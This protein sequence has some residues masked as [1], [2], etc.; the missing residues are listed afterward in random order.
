MTNPQTSAGLS[1]LTVL[2]PA[3]NEADRVGATIDSLRRQDRQPDRI[4]V[5]SDNSTDATVRVVRGLNVE[6]FETVGNVH[7]KAG[8]LNQAIAHFDPV[9]FVL[10][11]D[12]DTVLADGWISTAESLLA[13]DAALGAVGAVFHAERN[14]TL[15]TQF[16]ANEYTRYARELDRTGRVMVL[17]G[18]AA[19]LRSAVL[20]DVAR[21][22]S[23]SLPGTHGDVYDVHAQTEDNELTLAIKTLGWSLA[24]PA[25]CATVTEVMP[26]WGDLYRQRLRWYRGALENL[27]AYGVT[28]VTRRYW[29]QQIMLSVGVAALWLYLGLTAVSLIV[30]HA[31][32]LSPFWTGVTVVFLIERVVTAWAGGL[33]GRI[34]AGTL[35]LELFYEM[36]LQFVFIRAVLDIVTRREAKWHHVATA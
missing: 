28:P 12:A 14:D 13:A 2:I 6:V 22:R 11:M 9:G 30:G 10:V 8:A 23:T 34:L 21:S 32:T 35:Y 19:L 3:H 31:F 25:A 18:T 5:V 7:K 17:S 27:L 26:T 16:Q 20:R 29:A 4:I 15:L 36:F 24:S 33:R 1:S